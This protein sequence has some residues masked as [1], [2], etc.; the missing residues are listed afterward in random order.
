MFF[1]SQCWIEKKLE[2]QNKF[3]SVCNRTVFLR[4]CYIPIFGEKIYFLVM[5]SREFALKLLLL[6]MA[7]LPRLCLLNSP[8]TLL[9]GN[10]L[11]INPFLKREI[12]INFLSL[13]TS[14]PL[15]IVLKILN[16]INTFPKKFNNIQLIIILLSPNSPFAPITLRNQQVQNFIWQKSL[17]N[18][19]L[20][21]YIDHSIVY[22]VFAIPFFLFKLDFIFL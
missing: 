6:I 8:K 10:F 2:V 11:L 14:F 22:P 9:K 16:S 12:Q 3:L 17:Y 20:R 13:Q 5:S 21:I 4:I 15:L 1:L 18:I 7:M 19:L